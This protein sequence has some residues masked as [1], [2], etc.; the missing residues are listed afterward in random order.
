[1]GYSNSDFTFVTQDSQRFAS[2]NCY[3]VTLLS[4]A[5]SYNFHNKPATQY[6]TKICPVGGAITFL[7]LNS[8]QHKTN[9]LIDHRPV[10]IYK[11]N[12]P[13]Y[14]HSVKTYDGSFEDNFVSFH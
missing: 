4:V 8:G 2:D 5:P 9:Y 10:N 1:M 6:K 11:P 14:F 13:L 7:S 3:P 12:I